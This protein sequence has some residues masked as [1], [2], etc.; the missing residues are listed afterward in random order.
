MIAGNRLRMEA[1]VGDGGIFFHAIRAHGEGSHRSLLPVV[2]QVADDGEAGTA[3]RTVDKRVLQAVRLPLPIVQAFGADGDIGGNLSNLVR[4][5]TTRDN[6][7]T[8]LFSC[9]TRDLFYFNTMNRGHRRT[10]LSDAGDKLLALLRSEDRTDADAI[11]AV[12]HLP[13]YLHLVCDAID[14]WS[15]ANA[16]H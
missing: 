5:G 6:D 9:L 4:F 13:F 14:K 7:K 12:V 15:K 3:M 8:A 16:L 11:I 2:R 10:L 1:A